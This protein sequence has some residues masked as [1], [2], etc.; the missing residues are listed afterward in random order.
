VPFETVTMQVDYSR[1][2]KIARKIDLPRGAIADPAIG[3]GHGMILQPAPDQGAGVGQAKWG[4][5]R[6]GSSFFES[7]G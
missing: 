3:N 1:Q 6:H 4:D 7:P 2:D 5:L